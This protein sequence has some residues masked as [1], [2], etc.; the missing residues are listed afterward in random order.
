MRKRPI[1]PV[2]RSAADQGRVAFDAAIKENLEVMSGA[3]GNALAELS[4]TATTDEII[5]AI[6]ALTQRLQGTG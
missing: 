4:T 3:R 2:P 6:N 5:A 1:P